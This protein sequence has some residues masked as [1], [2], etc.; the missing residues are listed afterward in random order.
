MSFAHYTLLSIVDFTSKCSYIFNPYKRLSRFRLQKLNAIVLAHVNMA[1]RIDFLKTS[2]W[3]ILQI[4]F[5]R[6]ISRVLG[7]YAWFLHWAFI[8]KVSRK[9]LCKILL[10]TCRVSIVIL[11]LKYHTQEEHTNIILINQAFDMAAISV[12]E[13]VKT[14]FCVL[15]NFSKSFSSYSLTFH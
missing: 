15:P 3:L 11:H 2:N 14:Q 1:S 10:I 4:T 8:Y 5:K 13:I 7:F 6:G 9:T 12:V